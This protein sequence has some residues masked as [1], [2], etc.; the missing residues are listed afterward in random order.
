MR[1]LILEE[2]H[3][4]TLSIHPGATKM[5]LDLKKMFWWSGMKKV[6]EEYVAFCLVFQKEKVEHQ[7]PLGELQS[8]D[9]LDGK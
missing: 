7:R 5:Y 8:L 1:K 9:I 3:K 6:V 4:S 2:T